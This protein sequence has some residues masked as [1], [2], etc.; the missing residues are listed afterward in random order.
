MVSG[1]RAAKL[2]GRYGYRPG[3]MEIAIRTRSAPR[4]LYSTRIPLIALAI[5]SCWISPVPSKIVWLTRL[6]VC[7][8][9]NAKMVCRDALVVVSPASI[10]QNL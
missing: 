2:D 3:M 10:D 6:R 4:Q 7:D 5:T 8:V 9:P 1:L